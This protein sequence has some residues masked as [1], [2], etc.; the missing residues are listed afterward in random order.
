MV[1]GVITE[2][3]ALAVSAELLWKVMSFGDGKSTLLPKA[4]EGLIDA[5]EVEGDGG[6]GSVTTIKFNAAMGEATVMKTRVVALDAAT[7]VMR[8]EVLEGGKVR[9]QL[10]SQVLEMKMEDAG[11]GACVVKVTVEYERLDGAP[12][13][14]EDQAKLTQGY[15]A[16]IKKMEAYLVAHPEEFA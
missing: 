8:S 3:Y 10:K 11:E 15:L 13:A 2:E 4:C 1:A 9:A 14:A 12:L 7:R 16:L 5:V 6:A